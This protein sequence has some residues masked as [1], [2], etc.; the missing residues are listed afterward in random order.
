MKAF[1]FAHVQ[2]FPHRALTNG[3]ETDVHDKILYGLAGTSR[4]SE[5]SE[6]GTS[7]VLDIA[8]NDTST[9]AFTEQEL[10]AFKNLIEGSSKMGPSVQRT[11]MIGVSFPGFLYSGLNGK[12]T[13]W[14]AQHGLSIF[15]VRQT[16][17]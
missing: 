9:C 6:A 14:P 15:I 13:S 1:Y 10:C 16:P 17:C 12:L 4:Y 11:E 5:L 7:L 2:N 3:L 8:T